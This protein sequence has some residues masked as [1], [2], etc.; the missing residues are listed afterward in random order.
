MI[1]IINKYVVPNIH[2]RNKYIFFSAK[3]HRI[4]EISFFFY[5]FAEKREESPIN[6]SFFHIIFY[7]VGRFF[8]VKIHIKDNDDYL[9][10]ITCL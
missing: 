2:F 6:Y 3:T 7:F 1:C 4:V 5:I 10:N 9:C 8:F